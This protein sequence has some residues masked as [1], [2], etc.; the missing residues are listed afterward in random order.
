MIEWRLDAFAKVES[1]NAIREVLDRLEPSLK[2]TILV[3][4]FRSQQQG[5]LL[6]LSPEQI[7]DIQQVGAE[8]GAVD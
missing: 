4:T 5:G 6:E 8:S 7:Y 3:Y 1:L 2:E